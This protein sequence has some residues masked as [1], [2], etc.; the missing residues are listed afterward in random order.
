M[1]SG[2]VHTIK[3]RPPGKP[4]LPDETVRRVLDLTLSEPPGEATHWTGRLMAK[5]PGVSLRS[6]QRIWDAHG[7]EP[8]RI[9]AFKL[10]RDPL[11]SER[12]K[13][14]GPLCRSACPRGRA[15]GAAPDTHGTERGRLLVLPC[16]G[17]SLG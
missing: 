14:G 8:H 17:K 10:S 5:A 16:Q 9:R 2:G 13:A 1:P 6:V 7:L 11:L 15:L 3:P 12:L 4:R